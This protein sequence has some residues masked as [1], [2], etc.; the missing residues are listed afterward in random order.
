[1]ATRVRDRDIAAAL[2]A[3]HRWAVNQAAAGELKEML[4]LPDDNPAV[5][6]YVVKLLD[7]TP[8]LGKVKG[9]RLLHDLEISEFA[10]IC[11]LSGGAR[12]ALWEEVLRRTDGDTPT[13]SGQ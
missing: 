11:D 4:S 9:R 10:R 7:V 6:T 12:E 13:E 1:M 5:S 8:S 2:R 3:G